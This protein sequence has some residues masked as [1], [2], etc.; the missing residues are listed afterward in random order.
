MSD[1]EYCSNRLELDLI[2]LLVNFSFELGP[3]MKVTGTDLWSHQLHIPKQNVTQRVIIHH[4]HNHIVIGFLIKHI[5]C[6]RIILLYIKGMMKKDI[7][8]YIC[9]LI[10]YKCN[11]L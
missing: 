4:D 5:K 2:S 11:I 8:F 1:S 7:N 6:F 10:S 3:I 9:L